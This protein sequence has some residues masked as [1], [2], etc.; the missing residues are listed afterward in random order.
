MQP[1]DSP[2]SSDT[3]GASAAVA[4]QD[5]R[6]RR[7]AVTS[8]PLVSGRLLADGDTGETTRVLVIN[9]AAASRFFASREP[10]GAQIRFW[11]VTWTIVGVVGNEKFQGVT[12]DDPIA[13]YAPVAQSPTRGTSVLIA[14]TNG[15][16]SAL[17]QALAGTVREMDPAL[18][19]FGVETLDQ[20][21]LRGRSPALH[22]MMM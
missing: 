3:H 8:L 7:L 20:T 13:A 10:V 2:A 21:L 11:G 16:P 9:Q 18:A 5:A 22:T 12:E 15:N 14:R 1:I 4:A 19:V 6:F 17:G